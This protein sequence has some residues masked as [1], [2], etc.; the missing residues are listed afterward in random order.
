MAPPGC[1]LWPTRGPR[2]AWPSLRGGVA[3]DARMG[4]RCPLAPASG[5]LSSLASTGATGA[6]GRAGW[7]TS[8]PLWICPPCGWS[9]VGRA[10]QKRGGSRAR[11]QPRRLPRPGLG[12]GL[13]QRAAVLSNRGPGPTTLTPAAPSGRA[14]RPSFWPRPGPTARHGT[15]RAAVARGN[16]VGSNTGAAWRPATT[17]TCIVAQV[18]CTGRGLNLNEIK[19][20]H[21][22]A[23]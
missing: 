8:R 15:G 18:F 23:R 7:P 5:G 16:A 1:L 12:Q 6:H 4:A 19:R 22:L 3:R 11:S 2:R 10:P 20:Q 21:C 14:S 17:N 13:D 9:T